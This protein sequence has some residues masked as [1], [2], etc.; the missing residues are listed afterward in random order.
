MKHHFFILQSGENII[1]V[2]LLFLCKNGRSSPFAEL[3]TQQVREIQMTHWMLLLL[4]ATVASFSRTGD[5][6]RCTKGFSLTHLYFL[7]GWGEKNKSFYNVLCQGQAI[8]RSPMHQGKSVFTLLAREGWNKCHG[9]LPSMHDMY[10]TLHWWMPFWAL[11]YSEICIALL[12]QHL[13]SQI[14]LLFFYKCLSQLV[15][16]IYHPL[17]CLRNQRVLFNAICNFLQHFPA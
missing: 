4:Q 6:Q 14:A 13:I 5:A 12:F 17:I 2:K 1:C 7:W 11:H 15:R 10:S 16:P 8:W 3:R 9:L